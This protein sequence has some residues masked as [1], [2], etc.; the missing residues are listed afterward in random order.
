MYLF[1][2]EKRKKKKMLQQLNIRPNDGGVVTLV[3]KLVVFALSPKLFWNWKSLL[4]I[5]DGYPGFRDT[6]EG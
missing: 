6:I 2:A 4:S 3:S 5:F 1:V